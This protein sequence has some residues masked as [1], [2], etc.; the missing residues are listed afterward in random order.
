[1]SDQNKRVFFP[2]M[3]WSEI[4]WSETL[5]CSCLR[6]ARCM[7]SP[8]LSSSISMSSSLTR[9]GKWTAPKRHCGGHGVDYWKES[10]G[11]MFSV[12]VNLDS[13]DTQTLFLMMLKGLKELDKS[14]IRDPLN[15]TRTRP[16]SHPVTVISNIVSL[17][18][19]SI[20]AL[21]ASL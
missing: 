10:K 13:R 16:V 14:I 17:A 7:G 1:M 15:L 5:K 20:K 18:L 19:C 9:N 6:N 3:A 21:Q 12:S 2:N 11:R 4:H 8:S